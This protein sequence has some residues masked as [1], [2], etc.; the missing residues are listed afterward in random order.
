MRRYAIAGL[1]AMCFMASNA[2]ASSPFEDIDPSHWAYPKI[3]YLYDHG[4]IRGTGTG[5][6]DGNERISRYEA[7]ALVYQSMQHVQ[8]TQ[9]AGGSI[10]AD[11][12]D[13]INS[14]MTELTDEMQVMEVR[15]EEN[16]DS[17]AMLRNHLASMHGKPT[18]GMSIPMGQGRLKFM[19]QAMVSLV[20]GGDNSGYRNLATSNSLAAGTGIPPSSPTEGET[21]FVADY[22]SLALAA[23]IDERT[24]MFARANIY[25]GGSAGANGGGLPGT[26]AAFAGNPVG[27]GGSSGDTGL[28]FNDYIYLHVRDLWSDWDLT[29]GRMGLPW[30]HEVAGA[31]RTNP[32]FVSNSIVDQLYGN[33]QLTGAYFSTESD[34][35]NWNWGLGIHNG[36]QGN[37]A[38]GFT[39]LYP[40]AVFGTINNAIG[41]GTP[42]PNVRPTGARLFA[43]YPVSPFDCLPA[44][45]GAVSTCGANGVNN[46]EDDAFGFLLHVGARSQDGDFRWDLNFFTNGGDNSVNAANT[47]AAGLGSMTYFNLGGD[48]RVN[49]HWAV[50]AEYVQGSVEVYNDPNNAK[51]P[52]G[53]PLFSPTRG[54][55]GAI[56]EDDFT[57][58][59]LQLVYNMDH[60]SSLAL[61][62]SDHSYDATGTTGGGPLGTIPA[63]D[64]VSELALSYSRKVSDNGTL[65][66][67]Y[68]APD[69]DKLAGFTKATAG[70]GTATVSCNDD[71]DV[72]RA[73]YRVDF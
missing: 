39:H 5:R 58:W 36:D 41:P 46:N 42:D 60:K 56:V 72:V 67:E 54:I 51:L 34:D 61:R 28:K 23:D 19:G 25:T 12:M 9:A 40:A 6:F 17:I 50:S 57:T 59:Y 37:P 69:W 62:M 66:V 10:D 1:L 33:R 71:Y 73:S 31:F 21:E 11:I 4:I 49:E 13:T 35:G 8:R 44:V 63:D 53:A 15:I 32:Y 2:I 43:N 14:L 55:A 7:A 27:S 24:S 22:M 16:S 30:G 3:K 48:Y 20:M 38:S 52:A 68:S 65:I 29:L 64:E 18:Q 45:A 47:V 26:G 70:C